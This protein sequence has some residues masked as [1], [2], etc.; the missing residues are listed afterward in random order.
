MH[1]GGRSAIQ[2]TCSQVGEQGQW[3]RVSWQKVQPCKGLD[4]RSAGEIPDVEDV[5]SGRMDK[6][7]TH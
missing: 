1:L 5:G 4:A 6:W 3:G 7:G 2:C